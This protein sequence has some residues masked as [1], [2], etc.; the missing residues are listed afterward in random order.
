MELFND[1]IV[2]IA[3]QHA[4]QSIDRRGWVKAMMDQ[5]RFEDPEVPLVLV[6][7][8]NEEG[9]WPTYRRALA[10]SGDAPHHL[11]LQDD[12]GLCRDFIET[13]KE[14]IR[15]RPADLVALYTNSGSVHKARQRGESW[16]EKE[17][18][19]GPAVIWPTELIREFVE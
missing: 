6:E 15:V 19:A 3:I 13:V 1:M 8:T 5:L 2:S 10:A 12:L 17:G 11:M 18:G 9:C 14:L 16:I 7:D 4:P